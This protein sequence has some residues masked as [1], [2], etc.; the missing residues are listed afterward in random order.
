MIYSSARKASRKCPELTS[1]A[2]D[3]SS[4]TQMC[5]RGA[6]CWRAE[7]AAE[8]AAPTTSEGA[9]LGLTPGKSS[10]SSWAL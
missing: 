5:E 4:V 7:T 2:G 3:L 1:L 6:G 10:I 8:L 9:V